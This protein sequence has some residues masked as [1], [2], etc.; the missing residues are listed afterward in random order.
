MVDMAWE[1]EYALVNVLSFLEDA[2]KNSRYFGYS[3]SKV[4]DIRIDDSET[5]FKFSVKYKSEWVSIP[6]GC[7]SAFCITDHGYLSQPYMVLAKEGKYGIYGLEENKIL[8][9]VNLDSITFS[10]RDNYAVLHKDK[11]QGLFVFPNRIIDEHVYIRPHFDEYVA[12]VRY[13]NFND[14]Y[15]YFSAFAFMSNNKMCLIGQNQVKFFK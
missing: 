7:D 6:Y 15:H 4:T 12:P 10:K 14:Y 5:E 1:E 2:N 8:V 11:F 13:R 9:P 3:D